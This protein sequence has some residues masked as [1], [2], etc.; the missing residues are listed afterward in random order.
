MATILKVKF[1]PNRGTAQSYDFISPAL[2]VGN[3][4]YTCLSVLESYDDINYMPLD[5]ATEWRADVDLVNGNLRLHIL[6]DYDQVFYIL[7][8]TAHT[9]N[10]PV[11]F[12]TANSSGRLIPV[13]F[14]AESPSVRL[15]PTAWD[16]GSAD[17]RIIAAA[18]DIRGEEPKN[19]PVAFYEKFP[20]KRNIPVA[21]GISGAGSRLINV[22]FNIGTTH[23]RLINAAFQLMGVACIPSEALILPP[24]ADPAASRVR[25]RTKEITLTGTDWEELD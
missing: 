21:Y 22:A 14:S 18:Y 9:R 17:G 10:I 25:G 7:L 13:G 1:D 5:D 3:C 23:S 19:I 16:T 8:A 6:K 11:G 15:I 2:I 20:C 12:Y 24:D 4:A